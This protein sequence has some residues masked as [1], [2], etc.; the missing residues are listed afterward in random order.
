MS[1]FILKWNPA[2]SSYGMD[3]FN[4]DF[5]FGN[6]KIAEDESPWDFNWSVWD[7]EQAHEGDRFFM[8]KVGEGEN[9]GIV[10]SG[11][12]SSE[13]YAGEDWSGK[14]RETFYMDLEFD[15]VVDPT[16]DRVLPTA[17][18]AELLPAIEWTRGHSGV[19]IE[20]EAALALEKAWYAHL[21]PRLSA[22]ARAKAVARI[23][24][25]GQKDKAGEDYI[26]HPLRVSCS[27]SGAEAVVA[28]LHDVVE[29]TP[30]TLDDLAQEGFTQDVVRSVNALTRKA[31]ETYEDFIGRAGN[32]K[33]ARAVKMADLRDNLNLLR[34]PELTDEDLQ[35]VRK[36][37]K[38]YKYLCGLDN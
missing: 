20:P 30:V 6:K 15:I 10:M 21:K 18:L 7:H 27:L 36:Y 22:Y 29:D 5:C 13:P 14:G 28:V 19:L 38:A 33:M 35:R 8:L 11:M 1:T 9:N 37:H 16:T 31:G 25:F 2:I 26:L 24:H 23:A 4:D 32:N 34:L 3:R 12:F 17:L